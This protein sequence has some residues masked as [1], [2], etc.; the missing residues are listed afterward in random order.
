MVS[1]VSTLWVAELK[2][3]PRTAEKISQVHGLSADEVR[4]S[5]EC[6][7]GLAFTM[8]D[9]PERGTRAIVEVF[10]RK[11]RCLVV[12]YARQ[13]DAFGDAWNL[14]SAYPIND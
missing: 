12:L 8:D 3:S 7:S 11:R 9:H 2:I 13:D 5:V 6:V 10:I 1:M 14:G 4:E